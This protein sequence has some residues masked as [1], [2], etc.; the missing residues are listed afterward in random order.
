MIGIIVFWM[1]IKSEL[2][3][4]NKLLPKDKV[5]CN[6]LKIIKLLLDCHNFK[7]RCFFKSFVG[8]KKVIKISINRSTNKIFDFIKSMRLFLPNYS[9]CKYKKNIRTHN[10]HSINNLLSFSK[11]FFCMWSIE[12]NI[13][14]KHGYTCC[15]G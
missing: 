12:M 11:S 9:L 8:V 5:Y 13:Y 3:F 15:R 4:T 10:K 7:F 6:I 2:H 1:R 14:L